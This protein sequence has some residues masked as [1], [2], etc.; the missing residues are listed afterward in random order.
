M[1]V[2]VQKIEQTLILKKSLRITQA[3]LLRMNERIKALTNNLQS[4]R[5]ELER[6]RQEKSVEDSPAEL[7]GNESA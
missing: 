5:A 1:H 7:S 6:L 4:Q 2:S 3:K